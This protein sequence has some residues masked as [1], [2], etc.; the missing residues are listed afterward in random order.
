MCPGG[1]TGGVRSFLLRMCPPLIC[2]PALASVPNG[3]ADV[4]G[5]R[6]SLAMANGIAAVAAADDDAGGRRSAAEDDNDTADP[7]PPTPVEFSP[8]WRPPIALVVVVPAAATASSA[9]SAVPS[10]D[11]L[12]FLRLPTMAL[13]ISTSPEEGAPPVASLDDGAP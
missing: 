9:R 2:P 5:S 11:P 1:A 6:Y 8:R 7:P 4:R 12:A 3:G 10:S 13:D